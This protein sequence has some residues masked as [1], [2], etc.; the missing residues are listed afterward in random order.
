MPT[1]RQQVARSPE[2]ARRHP[3]LSFWFYNLATAL[4]LPPGLVAVPGLLGLLLWPRWPRLGASVVLVALAILW[5]VSVPVT[6]TLLARQLEYHAPFDPARLKQHP[7]E[8]IVVL[9]GGAYRS[10]PEYGDFDEVSR[11]TLERLRYAA[12]LHRAT[13]LKLA[14]SGGKPGGLATPEGVS[15]RRTLSADF[16]VAVTWSEL[17]SR[18]TAENARLSRAAFPFDSIVLVTHAMHMP[19]ALRA[20]EEAGFAVQAA[21]MGFYTRADMTYSYTDF[22]PD[23]KAFY[24][25][26]YAIYEFVGAIWYRCCADI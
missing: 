9:G 2:G 23:I 26:H 25:A 21:P 14:V 24:A 19:R 15:M 11:L 18:N 22:L 13:G 7:A 16:H 20:F 17:A 4:V 8:A 6:A 5:A 1:C 3:R 12:R 10:A